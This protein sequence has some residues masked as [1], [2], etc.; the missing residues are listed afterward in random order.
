MHGVIENFTPLRRELMGEL[1]PEYRRNIQGQSDA[2]HAFFLFLSYLKRSAG[3]VGG[4]APLHRIR[5]SFRKTFLMLNEMTGR[6]G[7]L[8]RSRIGAVCTNRRVMLACRQWGDLYY[9]ERTRAEVCPIC[10]SSH[11]VSAADEPYHAAV[12]ATEPLSGE[13]W[14]L[15]PDESVAMVDPDLNVIVEPID[16]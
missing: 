5:D 12:F 13:D 2:E 1:N 15:I 10:R 7:S 14:T 3:T 8:I 6:S 16:P 11:T 9:V 4:D